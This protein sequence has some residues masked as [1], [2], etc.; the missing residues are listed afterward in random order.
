MT[1][2]FD[3]SVG[4]LMGLVVVVS[5]FFWATGQ[6]TG[7][8]VLGIAAVIGTGLAVGLVNGLL[9]RVGR[10]DSIR[11]TIATYIVVQGIALQLRPQE[12]GFLRTDIT[13]AI[14]QRHRLDADRVPRRG[15]DHGD[16]GGRAAPHARAASACARS[17]PTRPGRTGS[18]RVSM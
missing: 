12:G 1:G 13:G 9:V 2:N 16:R 7:D 3:L 18:A 8:L 14:N 10:L 15:R 4:P 5:S 11:A 17:A 6:G